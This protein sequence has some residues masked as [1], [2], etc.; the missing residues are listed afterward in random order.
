LGE[1]VLAESPRHNFYLRRIEN[2]I[3]MVSLLKGC[4]TLAENVALL[5]L[6]FCG[7]V[8]CVVHFFHQIMKDQCSDTRNDESLCVNKKKYTTISSCF[9]Q[10]MQCDHDCLQVGSRDYRYGLFIMDLCSLGQVLLHNKIGLNR[11]VFSRAKNSFPN[12][13]WIE[14]FHL[15]LGSNYSVSY[16]LKI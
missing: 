9:F 1:N 2:I 15:C 16:S 5:L 3:K 4:V 10:Y 13:I 11:V 14:F 8:T 7:N 12:S 6:L